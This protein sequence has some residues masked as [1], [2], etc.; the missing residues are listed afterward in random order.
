MPKDITQEEAYD[1]CVAD[2]NIIFNLEPETDRIKAMLKIAEEQL[3][4]AKSLVQKKLWNST[5]KM[6]YEVLHLL[7]ETFLLCDQVKSRNHL[8]LFAY[9]CQKYPQLEFDWNFFEKVRTKRNGITYYGNPVD[10]LDWKEAALQFQLYIDLLKRKI[11][12]KLR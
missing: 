9:L 6:Y 11:K 2:G 5:Y 12:E 3:E 8:C 4:A 7:V 1:K 10:G